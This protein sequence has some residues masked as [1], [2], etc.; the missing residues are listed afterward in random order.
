MRRLVIL[1]FALISS[2]WAYNQDVRTLETRVADLLARMPVYN[3]EDLEVHM[4]LMTDIGD[5]GWDKVCSGIIEPGS[6]DDTRARFL[7][8]SYSRYLSEGTKPLIKDKWEAKCI[9]FIS[10]SAGLNTRLFFFSQLKIV[11]GEK[12]SEFSCNYVSNPDLAEDALAVIVLAGDNKSEEVLAAKLKD[13]SISTA[14]SIM[15]TLAHFKSDLAIEEYISWHNTGSADEKKAALNAMARSAHPGALKT[16][17]SA[18]KLAAYSWDRTSALDAYLNYASE[19]A[20][21]GDIKKADKIC[22]EIIKKTGEHSIQFKANALA[23]KVNINSSTAAKLLISDFDDKNLQYRSHALALAV[24]VPGEEANN[25]YLEALAKT[26]NMYVPGI[27]HMLGERGDPRVVP[28]IKKLINNTDRDIRLAALETLTVLEGKDAA[29][30]LIS[31]MHSYPDIEDQEKSFSLFSTIADKERLG[32]IANAYPQAGEISKAFSLMLL[33]Q[34]GDNK[35][36]NLMLTETGSDSD[37]VRNAA[38]VS[39]KNIVSQ[40]DIPELIELLTIRGEREE[41]I[42]V[43]QALVRAANKIPEKEKRAD[44]LIE[45]A[46]DPDLRNEII[47]V[48][49]GVGGSKALKLVLENFYNAEA[50]LKE[51]CFDALAGWIDNSASYALFDICSSDDKSYLRPAFEGYIRQLTIADITKDQKLLLLRKIMP[52]AETHDLKVKILSNISD[53]HTIPALMF[54]ARYFDDNVI[55]QVAIRSAM[56]IALPPDNER[57][58]LYGENVRLVLEDIIALIKGD[59]SEYEIERIKNYLEEMPDD[60]GFVSMFNGN[61][62]DGW[63]GLVEDPVA[64]SKMSKS[65]LARKQEEAN[66]KMKDNWSVSDNAIWFSGNGANL[67]SVKEYADFEMLVDWRISREGDSGIYL[68]GTPQVQI[69]DTSRVEVGAQVGSGGLYNNSVNESDPLVVADNPIDDWNTFRIIMIGERVSVW[70]NGELVVDDVIMENYWDRSIPIF[71]EGAIELQAHGNE[72]AFRD[73]YVREINSREYNLTGQER[74]EGFMALFNG[75]NLDNW[76]GDKSSY[77]VEDGTITVK[78]NQGSGGNLYTENEYSNFNFRFEFKLTE[79]ANNGLGIRA[80]LEGDAAYVGM[81]LQILD[82]R[83][84]IYADLEP[85]QYHGSVYGVIPA[86]RGFLKPLDEWNSEEVIVD[87]TRIK[88]ILN[89]EVIVDGDIAEARDKG[90]MDHRDHPGL[91]REKG[92]IGFLGHGSVLSFRNIR[93]KVLD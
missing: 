3:Q 34:G 24:S 25:V 63:Q 82:N 78:P 6:G 22:N 20:D 70:L 85:Y 87:G 26:E 66:K 46:S 51:L 56:Q 62:L 35:Y 42:Q 58:G 72:L 28:S 31:Y 8:E 86:K 80:P 60:K 5:K 23:L 91:K 47:P 45:A 50:G 71:P 30:D 61:D 7:I 14:A 13:K 93:I 2:L 43:Q 33:A 83:A 49:K 15:N 75:S 38:Y 29:A 64:R 67:C 89:G 68:R 37:L 40:D 65:E 53:I 19:L 55:N 10:S 54:A 27:I 48:L 32:M 18:A 59:G 74:L 79:G 90:T 39:L 9:E 57:V 69:W 52:Y 88:I 76:I 73:I 16:L 41:I 12:A 36:F 44:L 1:A 77:V 92:H 4:G 17:A 81:E 21:K 84:D 11:G